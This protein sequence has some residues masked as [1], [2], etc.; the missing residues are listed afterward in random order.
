VQHADPRP[1]RTE[2]A[3]NFRRQ[4]SPSEPDLSNVPALPLQ[5]MSMRRVGLN[6]TRQCAALRRRRVRVTV[7][8]ETRR[9]VL[10]VADR[11][12]GIP[13]PKRSG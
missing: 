7:R 8:A 4:E 9:A 12:P 3:G 1:S 10:E 11:G 13:V 2:V 6:L 5:A